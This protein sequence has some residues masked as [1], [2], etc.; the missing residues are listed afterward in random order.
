MTEST[1]SKKTKLIA[2]LTG[3]VR[4]DDPFALRR[5][6]L[7]NVYIFLS[8]IVLSVFFFLNYFL[9]DE[10]GVA[11]IDLVSAAMSLAALYYLRRRNDLQRAVVIN[12]VALFLF[13]LSFAY[14]NQNRDFGLLWLIFLPIFMI[15]LNGHRV[16]LLVTLLFYGVLFAMAYWHIGIWQDGAWNVHSFVRL[17]VVSLILTY[18]IYINELSIYKTNLALRQMRQRER[19]YSRRL[20]TLSYRDELTGV[21][22]RRAIH[23]DFLAFFEKARKTGARFSL[24]MF[25]IDHFKRINDTYGH[26]AGDRVLK[27]ICAIVEERI[28]EADRLGRWGGEEFLLIFPDCGAD[29]AIRKAEALRKAIVAQ[30]FLGAG[31]GVTASFGVTEYRPEDTPTALLKRVDEALY[32]A[33]AAGRNRVAAL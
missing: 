9:F 31:E 28:R 8:L 10:K 7:V 21:R 29:D 27:R 5:L 23:E 1:D 20:E 16:G 18:I 17:V 4:S 15:P 6:V 11:W 3:S 33:K 25:D 13:F 22:N 19:E 30:T 24:V 32:N 12:D 26:A 14:V 2:F